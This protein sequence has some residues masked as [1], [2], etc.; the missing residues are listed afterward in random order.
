MTK[1]ID[2]VLH[3]V[4]ALAVEKCETAGIASG[5]KPFADGMYARKGLHDIRQGFSPTGDAVRDS[6]PPI[7]IPA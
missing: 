1:Q 5:L 3:S 7:V 2:A 6:A 4:T